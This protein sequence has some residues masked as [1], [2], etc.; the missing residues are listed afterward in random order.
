M[1]VIILMLKS[2]RTDLNIE[3]ELIA[4][5]EAVKDYPQINPFIEKLKSINGRIWD[6][7]SDIRKGKEQELGLEEVGKRALMIR[8]INGERVACKNEITTHY[9]E[10]FIEVKSEHASQSN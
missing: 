9:N 1:I 3:A 2:E 8:D 4:Y 5:R 6:V 7:E 10:G